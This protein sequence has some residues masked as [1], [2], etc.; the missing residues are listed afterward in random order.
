MSESESNEPSEFFLY[1]VGYLVARVAEKLALSG[2][3]TWWVAVH[4]AG[5]AVAESKLLGRIIDEIVVSPDAPAEEPL[6]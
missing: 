5:H 1:L 2:S 6:G 4:E 3:L